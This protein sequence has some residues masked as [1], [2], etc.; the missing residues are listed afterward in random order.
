MDK[1]RFL[2]HF[3]D[4][5]KVTLSSIYDKMKLADRTGRIIYI[6]EFYTPNIWKKLLRI[7]NPFEL[8]IECSGIFQNSERRMICFSKEYEGKDFPFELLRIDNLSKFDNLTHRDYLGAIMGLGIVRNK[9]GDLVLED[10]CCYAAV[11]A[12]TAEFIIQNLEKINRCRCSIN[13]VEL[14]EHNIPDIKFEESNIISASLRLD[15]LVSS[16]CNISRSK[17]VE[18]INASGVSVDYIIT[19]EKDYTVSKDDTITIRGYGKYKILKNIGITGR[20]RMKL[21]MKKFV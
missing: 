3:C 10:N 15:S 18:L 12:E 14:S 2:N 8:E 20:E 13:T 16:I 7:N 6:N 1:T 5:D 4:D 9:L 17:A 19:K 11:C 21:L